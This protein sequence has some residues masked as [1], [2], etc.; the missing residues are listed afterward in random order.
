MAVRRLHFYTEQEYLA[1]DRTSPLRSDYME[2][3]VLPVAA[4]PPP[5]GTV[6]RNIAG[7]L[8]HKASAVFAADARVYVPRTGALLYPDVMAVCGDVQTSTAC[9]DALTNP[10]LI[11]E[12][13]NRE[14]WAYDVGRKFSH[15]RRIESLREFILAALHRCYTERYV[16]NP[17]NAEEWVLTEFSDPEGDLPFASLG[18]AVPLAEVYA[19]VEFPADVPAREATPPRTD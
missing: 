19:R 10:T 8:R 2:G 14:T 13:T 1:Y 5:H 18:V 12:V 9:A 4:Q 15:Y 16:R 17:A 3:S 7:L 11:V 6:R